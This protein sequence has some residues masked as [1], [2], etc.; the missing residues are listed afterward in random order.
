MK[1]S[2]MIIERHY[3]CN[4]G[5]EPEHSVTGFESITESNKHNKRIANALESVEGYSKYIDKHGYH[6][7]DALAEYAS[8]MMVNAN[9]QNHS[10]TANQVKK[11]MEGLGLSIPEKVTTGD[12]TYLANM[13]YADL[14]PDPL[15]DEASCLRAAYKSANDP[16][17]YE[18]MTFCRWTADV[19]GKAISINW[20]KF[21]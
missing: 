21:I 19:V 7:T 11:S 13:Y 10:W 5:E 8:K 14:Y 1:K 9:G 17:G 16:D 6:F 4:R 2:F 15:K 3:K 20:E 12:A 18:G